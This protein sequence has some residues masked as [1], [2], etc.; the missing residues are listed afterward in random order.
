MMTSITPRN[1]IK[2]LLGHI[3]VLL[4]W[5]A[6]WQTAALLV[7]REVVLPQPSAVLHRLAALAQ[8]A[9]FYRALTGSLVRITLG[10][11]A[12]LAAGILT[13]TLMYFFKPARALLAPVLTVV[14]STPVVSFILLAL[15]LLQNALIP[16]F[17]T[18][19]MVWPILSETAFSAFSSVDGA[20]LEMTDMYG[21]SGVSRL[22]ALYIPSALP[23]LQSSA[24]TALGLSWKSGVAAEVLCSPR[25]SIGRFLRESQIYLETADLLAYTVLVVV[26]SLLLEKLMKKLLRRAGGKKHGHSV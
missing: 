6:V 5:L 9:A 19:L 7:G 23:H 13:G 4:F 17:I 18:F 2:R 22:R 16:I 8:T 1:K 24:L 21:I 25:D 20:L 15:V 14:R 10:Y 12:G 11:I 3:G 26:L